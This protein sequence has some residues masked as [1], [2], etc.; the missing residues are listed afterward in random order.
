MS[1]P[2]GSWTPGVRLVAGRGC[3]RGA[4]RYRLSICVRLAACRSRC[5]PSRATRWMSCSSVI[6]STCCL[7]AGWRPERSWSTSGRPGCSC[8]S[9]RGPR[10]VCAGGRSAGRGAPV[11]AHRGDR[12]A[13]RGRVA[14]GDRAGAAP[15]RDQDHDDGAPELISPAP[16]QRRA[17]ATGTHNR[18]PITASR[19]I[20]QTEHGKPRPHG[21]GY[22]VP[23]P[24][25]TGA[26]QGK[27]SSRSALT[28]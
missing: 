14:A 9:R 4:W 19:Q 18:P 17:Q 8:G 15:P 22:V 6:A 24:T 20:D 12:N 21:H 3:R 25:P 5:R 11:A 10:R 26:E 13:A 1:A 7:S 23:T 16:R 27:H 28:T 2:S